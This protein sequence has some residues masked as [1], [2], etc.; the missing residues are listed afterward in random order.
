MDWKKK[1][2]TK[3]SSNQPW[4]A[5][6]DQVFEILPNIFLL[7]GPLRK[8]AYSNILKF[9]NK[10][11]GKISDKNF[12]Y[13]HISARNIDCWYSLEPPRRG[14]SNEYLQAMFSSKNKKIMY[15]HVNPSFT[16]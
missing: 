12:W 7:T 11:R 15:T 1:T 5:I 8:H 4:G 2:T 13:F 6:G 10:K 9:Y 14:G 3:N 16:I